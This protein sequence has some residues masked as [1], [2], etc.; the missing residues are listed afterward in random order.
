MN[1]VIVAIAF[2]GIL[3]FTGPAVTHAASC[4][5]IDPVTNSVVI[6]SNGDPM[7]STLAWGLTGYQTPKITSGAQ[8]VD[9]GG[10][11]DTC[12][13]WYGLM[14]CFD[15]TSTDYYRNSM[16]ALAKDVI[17]KGLASQFPSLSYW[18]SQVK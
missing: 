3:G 7:A 4:G 12:P 15:L 8:V 18:Y 5:S 17:A 9:A 14:G 10:I 6:C 11:K 2:V 16:I 13:A 1:K